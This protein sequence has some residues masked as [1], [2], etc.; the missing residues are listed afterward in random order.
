VTF[1]PFPTFTSS[2]SGTGH[3][4][5]NNN[6][7]GDDDDDDEVM[8]VDATQLNRSGRAMN[9][10]PQTLDQIND[11]ATGRKSRQLYKTYRDL[12]IMTTPPSDGSAPAFNGIA[13]IPENHV[14]L[15]NISECNPNS[16][17]G[18]RSNITADQKRRPRIVVTVATTNNKHLANGTLYAA[19]QAIIQHMKQLPN[20]GVNPQRLEDMSKVNV[21]QNKFNVA[22]AFDAGKYQRLLYNP[23]PSRWSVLPQNST[24]NNTPNTGGTER[25][26][27]NGNGSGNTEGS[28]NGRIHTTI[29]D[30]TGISTVD[31]TRN[32]GTNQSFV[33]LTAPRTPFVQAIINSMSPTAVTNDPTS[34]TTR[35]SNNRRGG[36]EI[37]PRDLFSNH[38]SSAFVIPPLTRTSTTAQMPLGRNGLR[39]CIFGRSCP[40]RTNGI[41]QFDHNNI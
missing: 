11:Q 3:Q 36:T 12:E 30:S 20:Y 21:N 6:N 23:L 41:C 1:S 28:E 7:N 38:R 37:A 10:A 4:G 31:G 29:D 17:G 19:L 5:T 14:Y 27:G 40:N 32:G 16:A 26:T 15:L 22:F 13:N 25:S 24:N 33:D 8:E 35:R 18:D 34:D 2:F 9:T 39:P